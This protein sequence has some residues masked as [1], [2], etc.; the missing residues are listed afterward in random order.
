MSTP[1]LSAPT[2]TSGWL[3]EMEGTGDDIVYRTINP[4]T[5]LKVAFAMRNGSGPESWIVG[6]YDFVAPACP[7]SFRSSDAAYAWLEYLTN[8]YTRPAVS[9]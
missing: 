1:T 8:L 5:G 2:D 4:D 6:V 7:A 3:V 9:A